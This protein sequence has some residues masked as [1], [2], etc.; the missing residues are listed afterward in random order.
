M[1][2]GAVSRPGGTFGAGLD[3]AFEHEQAGYIQSITSPEI[4]RVF[5]F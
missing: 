5:F 3:A 1:Q 2:L 4:C